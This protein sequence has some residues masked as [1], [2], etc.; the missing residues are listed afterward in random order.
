MKAILSCSCGNIGTYSQTQ[1]KIQHPK[2]PIP[3]LYISRK[4]YTFLEKLPPKTDAYNFVSAVLKK[5]GRY[6]Y[7]ID[8]ND[9][10]SLNE[11]YDYNK[12]KKVR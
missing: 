6:S 11:V 10:G 8:A 9:D 7:L 5:R 1:Y 12:K 2:E 4:G 3:T